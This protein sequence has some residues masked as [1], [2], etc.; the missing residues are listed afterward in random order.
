MRF[1]GLDVHRTFAEVAV[2]QGGRVQSRR[3]IELTSEALRSFA[4]RLD[5]QDQVV[6][7][8]TCNTYAIAR[9]LQGYAARVVISNP[10]QTRAIAAAKVKT[11]KV[12]AAVLAKL[13]ASG[14][15]P[16][17][18]LPDKSTEAL[19]RQVARRS[20][21][22]RHRTRLLKNQIHAILHRNL[23]RR[24]PAADL[25]GHKGRAWLERQSLPEDERVA[26]ESHLRALT[27]RTN[28]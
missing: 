11:D 26:V 21:L 7:E 1:I 4:E 10:L 3:R 13:L 14:F 18:W 9:L 15:L 20:Q 17:V 25:F 19:R 16:E 8:A 28:N 2:V 22:V 5:R 6:L 23:L 24:C 12:N 27:S